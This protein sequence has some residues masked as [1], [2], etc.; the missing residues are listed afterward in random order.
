ML[1]TPRSTST[2][3]AGS[4]DGAEW[5]VG[6]VISNVT[7]ALDMTSSHIAISSGI[8]EEAE[9]SGFYWKSPNSFHRSWFILKSSTSQIK[10]C[11]Q[12]MGHQ[13]MTSL[14]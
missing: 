11:L 8:S 5:V 10:L 3:I 9:Q 14:V 7:T 13:L 6:I 1:T 4:R 12:S 2:V